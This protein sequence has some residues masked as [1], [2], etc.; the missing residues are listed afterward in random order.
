MN[1]LW[2]A[3]VAAILRSATAVSIDDP[4][5]LPFYNAGAARAGGAAPPQG[6]FS[7]VF[8]DSMVFQ[9]S[10]P[11]A[12]WGFVAT[13]ATV[14]VTMMP[15]GAKAYGTGDAQGMWRAELPAIATPGGP[16]TV[17]ASY[18]GGQA[19]LGDV[20]IGTVLICS[21]QSNLSG[22]TTPLTYVFNGTASATEAD[23]FPFVRLFTVGEQAT[24]GL[25]PPQQQLGY[26]PRL[27]WSRA[28][29]TTAAGFSGVCWIAVKEIARA[30][31][32]AMPLGVIETAWSG[33]CIQ[34]WLP[35]DALASCGP[36]PPAQGWQTNSTLYNQ[37]VAP[38]AGMTVAGVICEPSAIAH[39]Q[40][41]P[42][43]A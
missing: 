41:R 42:D 8:G 40:F 23:A 43:C 29:A 20:E 18:S 25:L 5:A 32:P 10:A 33:T 21:G 31:G 11:I 13:G 15:G 28:N 3:I 16:Y 30:L 36:V 39:A 19:V 6:L 35:A 12:V 24:Q 4:N 27:P 1:L 2:L 34:G 14:T 17:T 38:F 22:A 9:H 26:A 7:N 37:I